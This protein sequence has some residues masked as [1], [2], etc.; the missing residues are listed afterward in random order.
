MVKPKNL[1]EYYKE[2]ASHYDDM[3]IK[4]NDEHFVALKNSLPI[5][6]L[7]TPT[8]ILDVGC[9]TGRA[10]SWYEQQ[11]NHLKLTGIDPSAD[12]LEKASQRLPNAEFIEGSGE[13]LPFQDNSFDLVVATGIM[14]HVEEP[15]RCIREMFRT[16]KKAV[17]ISDHNNFSFGSTLS[18]RIRLSLFAFSLLKAITFIKQ[19]FN[20][21]G[22]SEGDGYWY[23]YSLLNNYKL[24]SELSEQVFIFPTRPTNSSDLSNVLLCQSHLAILATKCSL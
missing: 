4:A 9:G 24:I 8:S 2:T 22:Y 12:L 20:H 17:L 16:A 13:K 15:D 10:L 14:H 19:G 5:L 3:H 23:P 21:Q 6:K 11:I 7:L 1:N 18:R